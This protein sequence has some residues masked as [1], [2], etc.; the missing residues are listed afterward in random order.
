MS[1]NVLPPS[2]DLQIAFF[3]VMTNTC[4]RRASQMHKIE[5][6]WHAAKYW[7]LF[8]C[9]SAPAYASPSCMHFDLTVQGKKISAHLGS[10]AACM[11]HHV[12]P[13]HQLLPTPPRLLSTPSRSAYSWHVSIQTLEAFKVR[14][15]AMETLHS[16]A[17][18]Q[19]KEL[20]HMQTATV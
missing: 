17:A 16:Q 8:L 18:A 7:H 4:C 12:L 11:L 1:S 9:A 19:G 6:T 10:T 15:L 14:L 20:C 2:F 3:I 13:D 5:H